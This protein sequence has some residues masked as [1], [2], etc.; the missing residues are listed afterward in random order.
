MLF[1]YCDV[2]WHVAA[3][4]VADGKGRGIETSAVFTKGSC[5]DA[6]RRPPSLLFL[7]LYVGGCTPTR[8]HSF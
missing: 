2:V 3:T 1:S 8:S 7:K 4:G 5:V 6:E